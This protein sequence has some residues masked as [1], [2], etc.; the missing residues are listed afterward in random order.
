MFSKTQT[1]EEKHFRHTHK[2]KQ[3]SIEDENVAGPKY[4]KYVDEMAPGKQNDLGRR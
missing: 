1:Y 3:T 2:P 4:E